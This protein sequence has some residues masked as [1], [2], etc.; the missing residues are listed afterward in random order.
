M[1]VASATLPGRLAA[2]QPVALVLL[3]FAAGYYLSYLFRTINALIATRLMA[4]LG[5]KA[6]DLGALTSVFFLSF[7]AIQLPLGIMLDRYGP[8]RV[9][10]VLLPAA[11]LGAALFAV[12]DS[13]AA[14]VIARALIGVGVAGSLMAGL[15]SI[16]LWFPR[17]RVSLANG[18]FI[19]LGAL[20]AVTATAPAETLLQL[21]GWRGLFKVLAALSTACALLIYLFA[22]DAT[23]RTRALRRAYG[24]RSVYG[25]ARF[26]RLAPLSATCIGSAWALHGL[27]A[28]PWLRDVAGLDQ[29]AIV[30]HLFVM[31]M[32]ACG[33]AFFLGFGADRFGQGRGRTETFL[34]VAAVLFIAA[35]LALALGWPIPTALTWAIVAGV[36]AATVLSFAILAEH[37]PGEIAGRANAALNL[38]H[39]GSAFVLQ[40]GIGLVIEQWTPEGGRYPPIAYQTT[41]AFIIALQIAALLWFLRPDQGV[42]C[43]RKIRTVAHNPRTPTGY[44]VRPDETARASVDPLVT[45]RSDA[46]RWRRVAFVAGA[47]SMLLALMLVASAGRASAVSHTVAVERLTPADASGQTGRNVQASEA[48]VAYALSRFIE[49]I[50]SLSTDPVVVRTKWT[51]AFEM[52]TNQGAQILNDF[53]RDSGR[54]TSIGARAI[55]AKVTSV[56]RASAASLEIHWTESAFENGALISS[57][58]LAAVVTIALRAPTDAPLRTNPFSIYVH[59]ISWSLDV[60]RVDQAVGAGAKCAAGVSGRSPSLRLTSPIC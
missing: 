45:A 4:D 55:I 37:F 34:A 31:A 60:Q 17:E 12:A 49:D 44:F 29:P 6:A 42:V 46:V 47:L 30:Q 13:F 32:A 1:T 25:D 59:D 35:Q 48:Q 57:Q 53:G 3:P 52:V 24:L 58:R 16:I 18:C 56:V 27:W 51:R 50:R 36:G 33:G 10:T 39:V 15:K 41:F 38:L 11:A 21:I 54:L 20:G 23:V 19:M 22:P 7:A 28:A 5:L 14:L 2:S 8:R 9:Q 40:S 43:T 26:W